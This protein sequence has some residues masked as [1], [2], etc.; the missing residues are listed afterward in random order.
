[1]IYTMH[2]DIAAILAARKFPVRVIYGPER[3][4]RESYDPTIVIERDRNGSDRVTAPV[5]QQTNPRKYAMRSLAVSATIYTVSTLPGAMIQDHERECEKLID[6][7]IVALYEWQASARAGAVA[8]GEARYLS[9]A[10][11]ND[12]ETWPGVAYRL[13]FTV[14][15]AVQAL[16]YQGEA[17]P[18]GQAA[19]VSNSTLVSAPGFNPESACGG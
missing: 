1:M 12:V 7:F 2:R 19:G 4:V 14:P 15:R 18:T 16:T 3:T 9:A 5:G 8:I 11:R 10:D 13:R 6:A 17:R